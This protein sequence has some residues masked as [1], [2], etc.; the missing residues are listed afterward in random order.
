MATNHRPLPRHVAERLAGH[1]HL[2]GEGSVLAVQAND[3]RGEIW[4]RA[5][6]GP[7]ARA[8]ELEAARVLALSPN[9]E[10]AVRSLDA[11]RYE[12]WSISR[13]ERLHNFE[14]TQS[15]SRVAVADGGR[16]LHSKRRRRE[17]ATI[18]SRML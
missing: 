14:I 3:G 12:V 2:A 13:E 15:A 10:V 17:A 11:H 9:G 18:Q 7:Y 1:L 5:A 4:R 8:L 16:L 6:G